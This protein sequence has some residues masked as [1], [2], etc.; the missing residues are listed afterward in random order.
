MMDND[1][2]QTSDKRVVKDNKDN[3]DAVKDG[4]SNEEPVER[5]GHLLGRQDE[6]RD[7][8]SNQTEETKKWL[9]RIF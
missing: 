4:K 6:N 3:E 7:D 5:V 9:K 1:S 8:I 2:L